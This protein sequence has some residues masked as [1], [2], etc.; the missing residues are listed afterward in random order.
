M[1][2][3]NLGLWLSKKL[4]PRRG[5]MASTVTGAVIAVAGV[6]LALTVM[7]LSIAI[8]T[9]FKSEIKRKVEG[10]EAPVAITPPYDYQTGTSDSEMYLDD[11]L[12]NI[13]A[14]EVPGAEITGTVSR[15]AMIKTDSDFVAVRFTGREARYPDE[16]ARSNIIEGHFPDATARDS[17]VISAKTAS[18]LNIGP[19]RKVYLYFFADGD[20]K[21]RRAFVAGIYQS[22]FAEYDENTAY[23]S[24]PMLAGVG[25]DTSALTSVELRGIP[26]DSAAAI[27][28]RLQRRLVEAY[29]LG[30][31]SHLHPVTNITETGAI[32]FN[33]LNLLDTNVVVIFILMSCVA[34]FTLISSL[35]IIILDNVPAIGVL[36]ALGAGKRVVNTTFVW[37]ALRL[38]G[39]GMI[40]GNAVG[41]GVIALQH[42]THLMPLNPEMYYLSYV[43]VQINFVQVAVLNIAVAAGAW[44]IL[45]L[46]SRL[47]SRI[48]PAET[49]RYE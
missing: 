30:E 35:F 25:G 24:A 33:W 6:A 23:A 18:K 10:F 47:A 8:V 11:T 29:R 19:G 39:L 40:I 20:V 15:P 34:I 14:A 12:R 26:T 21:V 13:V 38:V 2:N 5:A 1:N 36:R 31:I 9:G 46:P 49:M 37:M 44:L 17:I 42:Y 7:E 32:F 28:D 16:F 45:I 43:P 22:N 48:D 41:L 27:A 3:M 4:Q